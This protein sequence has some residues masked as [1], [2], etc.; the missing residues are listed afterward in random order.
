MKRLFLV[1]IALIMLAGC[2]SV[3]RRKEPIRITLYLPSGTTKE[4]TADHICYTG[5]YLKFKEEGGSHIR[6][7][8]TWVV[9]GVD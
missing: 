3:D 9:T 7:S 6:I 8:G 2:E 5:D 4:W 1:V